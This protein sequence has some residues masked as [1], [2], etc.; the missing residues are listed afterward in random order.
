MCIFPANLKQET[1]REF[2]GQFPL[3]QLPKGVSE[4]VA[5]VFDYRRQQV[6]PINGCY[7]IDTEKQ[8]VRRLKDDP[9]RSEP[10]LNGDDP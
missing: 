5:W 10:D 3:A 2:H 4:V 1:D 8:T 9:R 6:H 7:R